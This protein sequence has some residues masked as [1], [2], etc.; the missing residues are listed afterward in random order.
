MENGKNTLSIAALVLGIVALM[1]SFRSNIT[2]IVLGVV[3]VVLA[4]KAKAEEGNNGM[5]TAGKV[6]AIIAFAIAGLRFVAVFLTVGLFA[7]LV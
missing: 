6:C 5:A 4:S 7:L 1:M 3:A 2:A